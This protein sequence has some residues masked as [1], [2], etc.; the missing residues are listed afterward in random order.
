MHSLF[1]L[2]RQISRPISKI[3]I[4]TPFTPNQI[5]SM[6]LVFGV[7][8]SLLFISS[9]PENKILGSLAFLVSYIFDNCD[10]EVARYKNLTSNF[11]KNFDTFVDWFVHTLLFTALGY[12][13]AQEFED[14]IWLWLGLTGSI[15][16]TINYSIVIFIESRGK[17]ITEFQEEK[18][19]ITIT[20]RIIFIFRESFRSDFCFIILILALT[21]F[22][23]VLLPAL[24]V[25]A[26]VYWIM[27]II[28]YQREYRG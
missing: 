28:S 23:W 8:G 21:D 26:Q 7:I 19:P 3:L 16:G 14:S 12:G 6:S 1:P 2:I 13:S 20:D 22:L 25:G 18:M 24:A 4:R 9:K 27:V 17:T 10:G 5:T 11:G 15:G